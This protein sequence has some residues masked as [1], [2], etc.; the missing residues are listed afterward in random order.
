MKAGWMMFFAWGFLCGQLISTI[1]D[2]QTYITAAKL[3]VIGAILKPEILISDSLGNVNWLSVISL[4]VNIILAFWN[5]LTWDFSFLQGDLIWV[6]M[7]LCVFTVGFVWGAAQL[8]RGTG[9]A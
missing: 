7:F 2:W 8:V 3:S 6:R 1:V 4:P 9:G 5:T